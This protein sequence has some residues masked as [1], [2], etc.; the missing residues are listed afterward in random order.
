MVEYDMHSL[1][2]RNARIQNLR[3]IADLSLNDFSSLNVLVGPNNSGKT[4][5]LEALFLLAGMSNPLL[6]IKI[7]NFRRVE[8]FVF[9]DFRYN[10]FRYNFRQLNYDNVISL[11]ASEADCKRKVEISP[12]FPNGMEGDA[13]AISAAKS[14]NSTERLLLKEAVGLKMSCSVWNG[15]YRTHES[16]I[17]IDDGNPAITHS[18]HYE[19]AINARMLNHHTLQSNL[20]ERFDTLQRIKLKPRVISVLKRIEPALLDLSMSANG[21]IMVDIGFSQL[22]PLNLMGDGFR[23]A[24]AVVTNLSASENSVFLIDEIENGLHFETMDILWQGIIEAIIEFR[25]QVFV[26]TH[27]YEAL[28]VLLKVFERLEYPTEILRVLSI[29][30]TLDG[31]HRSYGYSFSDLSANIVSDTEIRGRFVR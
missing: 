23:K 22:A 7:N 29:N 12:I 13:G 15:E 14:D 8:N 19:E 24:T 16:V 11:E 18:S 1:V 3:G 9:D 26:T 20:S 17:Q 5:V 27:S 10:D 4:T 21:V 25:Q 31:G 30:R 28:K 2:L 6:P